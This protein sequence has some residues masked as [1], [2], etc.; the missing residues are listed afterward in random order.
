MITQN[1][2]TISHQI[3]QFDYNLHD[4]VGIRLLDATPRDVEV[5]TRQLGPIQGTLT[6]EPD[7]T[8]RFVDRLPLST[9]IRYLG[10]DDAGFTEDAFLVL[11]G[12]H[13]AHVKVQIP[14]EQIGEQCQIL[15]ERGAP[16]VPLL[17]PIL[18]LTALS[19]GVL[20][21]HASA[22]RYQGTGV[23]VT[24]WAKGGKTETL[25][26]FAAQGAEYIGDEWIYLSHDGKRM[27]GIPEPIRIWD[28]HLDDMPQYWARLKR[29]ERTR[30][31]ALRFVV[32][33][34]DK[35]TNGTNS[36]A[37][38]VKLMNRMQ[39]LLKKQLHTNL[40]PQKLFEQM[41]AS[42]CSLDKIFFV[43]SH[44]TPDITVQPA[45]PQTIARRMVF[46]LQ[47][48]RLD[49]LSYYMKFRFAFPELRNELI[50][51]AEDIQHQLLTHILAE[52]EAYE[53]YHP[54]PVS[55]PLLFDAISPLL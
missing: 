20:P 7:I 24:G 54:Y 34:M 1:G 33:A 22:F 19:R 27:C 53:V 55:I 16:A 9:P 32:E 8:I 45:D 38:P 28:W 31:Q 15:C 35:V 40:P 4:I 23:L 10:V 36:S 12:K 39:P 21:L 49:F 42:S 11:R 2:H 44:E 43:A 51:Q 26:A 17:I 5:V 47:E 25:L 52:K 37:G 13:K 41:G 14:I 50:E 18:N 46:S 6:R 29:S 30:L 3:E 48:E